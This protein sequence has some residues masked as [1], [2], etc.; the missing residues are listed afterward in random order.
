[1]TPKCTDEDRAEAKRLSRLPKSRQHEAV[2]MIGSPAD[3]PNVPVEDQAEA[4]RRAKALR[5]LLRFDT[6]KKK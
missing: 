5:N 3:D 4:S 2:A 1:M 6:P